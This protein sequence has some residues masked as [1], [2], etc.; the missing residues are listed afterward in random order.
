M[1]KQRPLLAWSK[2]WCYLQDGTRSFYSMPAESRLVGDGDTTN[3]TDDDGEQCTYGTP[4]CSTRCIGEALCGLARAPSFRPALAPT[5]HHP[6]LHLQ[7]RGQSL[8]GSSGKGSHCLSRRDF[9]MPATRPEVGMRCQS[10]G[11]SASTQRLARPAGSQNPSLLLLGRGQAWQTTPAA[12]RP[13]LP[14]HR[15][16]NPHRT[17]THARNLT[18]QHTWT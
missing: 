5:C 7:G 8:V 12:D 3:V 14:V 2:W 10:V 11:A 1:V 9:S 4:S 17:K 16:S 6:H 15:M 13:Y 18:Q